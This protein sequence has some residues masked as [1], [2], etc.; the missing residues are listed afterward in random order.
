MPGR[1]KPAAAALLS[2][3][4][5]GVGF[6]YLF[7]RS[8]PHRTQRIMQIE[9]EMHSGYGDLEVPRRFWLDGREVKVSD[10][11][12]QWHGSG[13]RYF[14]LQGD[15]GNLYILRLDESQLEWELIMF[16]CA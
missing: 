10:N 9:V 3:G 14:K 7:A 2:H 11:L 6:V 16:Q 4:E 12:D 5:T 13:H 8:E 1:T 15:D